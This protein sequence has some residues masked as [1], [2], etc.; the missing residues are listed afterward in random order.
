MKNKI[1]QHSAISLHKNAHK[2]M[3]TDYSLKFL[4]NKINQYNILLNSKIKKIKQLNVHLIFNIIIKLR[5]KYL[6]FNNNNLN[7]RMKFK[8]K[9]KIIIKI[10]FNAI[11]KI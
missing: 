5:K 11:I 10:K 4:I 9:I 1:K 2:E 3:L 8:N 7:K 6:N